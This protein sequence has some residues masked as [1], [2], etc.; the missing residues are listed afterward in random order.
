MDQSLSLIS[1]TVQITVRIGL[2]QDFF[3]IVSVLI[4][5]QDSELALVHV[6]LELYPF[7][8]QPLLRLLYCDIPAVDQQADADQD[9][10]DRAGNQPPS[11]LGFVNISLTP[12]EC[13]VICSRQLAE[14]FI[15]PLAAKLNKL[16][17][18]TQKVWISDDDFLAMQVEGQ[19]LDAGRRVLELTGPLA[20]A[21]MYV[22]QF[23]NYPR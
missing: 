15:V 12:V 8:V 2:A 11:G 16:A 13:S 9:E 22:L 21:G 1:A 7:F 6:P 3:L 4:L 17:G 5:I 20:L 10:A 14:R 23:S 19:G 18:S